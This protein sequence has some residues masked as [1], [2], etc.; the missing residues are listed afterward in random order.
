VDWYFDVLLVLLTIVNLKL[1][2]ILV[3]IN[4]TCL[5][6]FSFQKELSEGNQKCTLDFM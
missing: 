5:Q 6:H 3:T 1:L 4:I 2:I